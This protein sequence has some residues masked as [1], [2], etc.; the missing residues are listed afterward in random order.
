MES[1]RKRNNVRW[2]VRERERKNV[3]WKVRERKKI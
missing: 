2:K 3:R 1:I